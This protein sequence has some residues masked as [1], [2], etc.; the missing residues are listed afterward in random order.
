MATD[1]NKLPKHTATASNVAPNVK[2]D[3]FYDID[4]KWKPLPTAPP[5]PWR[6]F[7]E[8]ELPPTHAY[9]VAVGKL[10]RQGGVDFC[11][12]FRKRK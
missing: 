11:G 1:I 9:R 12:L 5:S 4:G 10:Y 2:F 6:A 7:E 3:E 8:I